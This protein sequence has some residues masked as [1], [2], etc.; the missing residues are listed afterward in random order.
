[1]SHPESGE[2]EEDVSVGKLYRP[3]EAIKSGRKHII[4]AYKSARKIL[5]I[6][7]RNRD[8]G[9]RK[10]DRGSKG[11]EKDERKERERERERE[12]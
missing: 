10:D 8:Y 5:P 11:A 7:A 6:P 12:R 1:M 4:T 3:N 2:K 9:S